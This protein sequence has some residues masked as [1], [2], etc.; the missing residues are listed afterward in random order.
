MNGG[1][2]CV[3]SICLRLLRP[4]QCKQASNSRV[5]VD[6]ATKA[7][8]HEGAQRSCAHLV[9]WWQ[10]LPDIRQQFYFFLYNLTTE[11]SSSSASNSQQVLF[12]TGCTVSGAISHSGSSTKRRKCMRL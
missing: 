12:K 3:R 8:S 5:V 1:Q 7:P 2:P 10:S 11:G 9:S 6:F 4:T